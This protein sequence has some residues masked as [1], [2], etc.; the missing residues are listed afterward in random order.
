MGRK[1]ENIAYT[2]YID[3]KGSEMVIPPPLNENIDGLVQK[4]ERGEV[5][6]DP[7]NVAGW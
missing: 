4:C 1:T 6:P 5:K 7:S 3:E 2:G